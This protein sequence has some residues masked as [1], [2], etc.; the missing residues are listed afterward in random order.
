MKLQGFSVCLA[1]L[2]LVSGSC[3]DSPTPGPTSTSPSSTEVTRF[4]QSYGVVPGAGWRWGVGEIATGAQE[5]VE[6]TSTHAFAW[7]FHVILGS[8]EI[9][10]AEGSRVIS[11][12]DTAIVPAGQ[13]HTHRYAPQ[14]RVLVFRPADRPFGESFHRATR[15]YESATALP[16]TV[17]QSYSARIREQTLSAGSSSVISDAG[18]GYVVDGTLVVSSAGNAS[19][20]RA[21][22]AFGLQSG[23]SQLLF[24]VGGTSARFILVDLH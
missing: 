7:I 10:T 12:G 2:L 9:G 19:T 11:A 20:Q 14:S 15:L 1:I 17:G 22:S 4:D 8:A 3:T 5:V 18:F 21:G 13:N 16:L 6:G 23:V 24:A